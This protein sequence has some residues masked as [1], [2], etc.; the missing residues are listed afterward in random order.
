MH[1]SGNLN[2]RDSAG[3]VCSYISQFN[4]GQLPYIQPPAGYGEIQ[5]VLFALRMFS[6]SLGRQ[7]PLNFKDQRME[8]LWNI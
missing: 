6:L 3:G 1:F 2:Q 4:V 8:L 5:G 7:E